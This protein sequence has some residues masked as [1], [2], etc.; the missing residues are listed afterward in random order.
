MTKNSGQNSAEYRWLL[1]KGIAGLGDRMQCVLTG[2]LYAR[3]TGRRLIVDWT[4]HYYSSDGRNAFHQ[5]FQCALCDPNDEIPIKD[6]VAPAIW[7]GHLR[8]SAWQMRTWHGDS[9]NSETWRDF[10]IDLEKLEHP[11]DV[12]VLWT[13]NDKID[14]LRNHFKGPFENLAQ[15]STSA[16]LRRLLRED[17]VLNPRIRERID[18]FKRKRFVKR[19]VG[20]HVRYTD[21]RTALWATLGTL[22]RLLGR[23]PD[24]QVFL[25]T[26]NIKIKE[27]FEHSYPNVI[28]APHWYSSTAGL[29]LHTHQKRRDPIENGLEAL[30]DLYLLAG[31]DYLIVDRSSHFAHVATLLANTPDS[32]IFDVR[33]RGKPSS[34]ASRFVYRW[35]YRLML[36]SG[37]F[38]W[39]LRAL[40]WPLKLRNLKKPARNE[41]AGS[42]SS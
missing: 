24:L 9:N 37:L 17:L 27:L 35:T 21:Y 41:P 32:K 31:C 6:S 22:N 16:I 4:D 11:E 23:E 14:M 42:D 34:R 25:C 29:A 19:T 38:S 13:Y 26:D 10:S 5:F 3:L 36:K 2:I 15:E 1:V 39:G 20:V 33:R 8:D 28:T 12:V 18:G 7:K 30:V 40:A